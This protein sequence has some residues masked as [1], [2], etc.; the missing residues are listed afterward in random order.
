M[1]KINILTVLLAILI[2]SALIFIHELGHFIAARKFGVTVEEFSIGMG[3]KLFSKLSRS[4]IRY[5]IRLLPIGGYVSMPGEN[6]GSDDPNSLCNKPVLQRI[7]VVIAGALMN[8]ILGIVIM[9]VIVISSKSLG[10]TTVLGFAD[11]ALSQQTGLMIGDTILEVDSQRV[12]VANDLVYEIMRSGISPIDIKVKRAGEVITVKDVQFPS[13][14]EGGVLY[15]QRD[16][17]VSAEE[18]NIVNIVKHSFY[19]SVSTVKMIWESL[20]DLVTGRYGVEAISGPVG[21]TEAISETAQSGGI[22]GVLYLVVVISMNL[23]IFNLLPL[24]ALDGGR[25]MFLIVEAVRRRPV[26]PE[27][28]AKIHAAGLIVL[29]LLMV[30]VTYQ[31]I[32]RLFVK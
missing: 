15:A 29:M 12:H 31:D 7:A 32:S 17:Y 14:S 2:F 22:M 30:F 19:R 24:P 8:F 9:A 11:G 18:K 3:P 27:L 21:V 13:F 25:L 5:S 6:G 28:E 20:I 4:R 10:S 23:G 26:D 1:I 16:F